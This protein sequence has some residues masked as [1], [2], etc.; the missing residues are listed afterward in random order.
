MKA[1][2]KNLKKGHVLVHGN[3]ST[4]CGNPIELLQY[5]I[6]EF[7]G[8]SVVGRG[9]VVSLRFEDGEDLLGS[10]SPHCCFGNV[11]V[12]KNVR[13]ELVT[14]YMNLSDEIVIINSIGENILSQLSG[15]D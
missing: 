11:L 14:K 3:Y 6:G 15:A 4:L 7:D 12:V 8:E 2:Y 5:V 9:N 10:R 13:N 1:F